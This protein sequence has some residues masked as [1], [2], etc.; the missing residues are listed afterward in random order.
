MNHNN[1]GTLLSEFF[2]TIQTLRDSDI[3]RS[4]RY[5]GD[6]G[7]FIA[8]TIFNIELFENQRE[9]TIDGTLNN[10]TVQVKFNSS[11]TKTNI[12]VGRSREYDILVLIL[13]NASKHFPNNSNSDFVGYFIRQENIISSFSQTANN[14]FSCTKIRLEQFEFREI[15]F[16]DLN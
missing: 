16:S 8:S 15:N 11:P 3:I 5:L 2:N 4:D 12:N 10:Q 14:T 7:E 9:E 13:S 6:I 1:Q